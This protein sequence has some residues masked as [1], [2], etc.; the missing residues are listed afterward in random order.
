MLY[1]GLTIFIVYGIHLGFKF[2]L[3][4]LCNQVA[5]ETECGWEEFTFGR[6]IGWF[7][8]K[9]PEEAQKARIRLIPVVIVKI[10]VIIIFAVIFYTENRI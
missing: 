5:L 6:V 7:F 9:Q 4:V 10:V 8:T 2:E 1:G 3:Q